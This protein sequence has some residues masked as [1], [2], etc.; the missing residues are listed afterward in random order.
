MKHALQWVSVA[1]V[2]GALVGC[3]GGAK[4]GSK[5]EAANVAFKAGQASQDAQTQG[6]LLRLLQSADSS[7][8]SFTTSC[9]HGG[10]VTMTA[11]VDISQNS[12][13]VGYDVEFKGCVEPTYDDPNTTAVEHD[14]VVYD[15]KMSYAIGA[16]GSGAAITLK[17]RVDLGGALSD[18]VQMDLTETISVTSTSGS[19]VINGTIDTS[20]DHYAYDHQSYSVIDGSI[21]TSDT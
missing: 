5:E 15:G 10:S 9:S 13:N 6:A 4:I 18:Y 8:G 2:T 1:L 12:L 21:G 11:S 17:G 20:S 16:D 3:G 14:D 19:V 7:S